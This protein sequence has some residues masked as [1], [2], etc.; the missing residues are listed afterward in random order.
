MISEIL[1][2]LKVRCPVPQTGE[3]PMNDEYPRIRVHRA[4]N[5]K[6]YVL[7]QEEAICTATGSLRYFET[8]R[9]VR[10]FLVESDDVDRLVNSG[11]LAA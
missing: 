4:P 3:D 2:I 8:V 7:G 6:F 5:N 1:T 9:E 11:E 10:T